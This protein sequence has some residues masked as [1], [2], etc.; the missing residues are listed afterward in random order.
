MAGKFNSIEE[1][2]QFFDQCT[3]FWARKGDDPDV[4][5]CKAFWWD[6]VE[7]SNSFDSWDPIKEQ[8]ALEFCGYKRGGKMPSEASV[9]SGNCLPGT[10]KGT[11][12]KNSP[13]PGE[14]IYCV[15][16]QEQSH[17]MLY[18]YAFHCWAKNAKDAKRIANETW[19]ANGNTSHMFHIKAVRSDSQDAE[20]L[21]VTDYTHHDVTGWN[22]MW[23]NVMTC[24]RPRGGYLD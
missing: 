11:G 14:H 3:S 18:D 21:R 19:E 24:C 23:S 9:R 2:R 16:F 13:F 1:I 20:N 4:A 15:S 8:F 6:I 12:K 17:N 5:R 22:T 7:I 10:N